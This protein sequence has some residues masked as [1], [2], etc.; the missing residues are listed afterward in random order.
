ME[1]TI[2]GQKVPSPVTEQTI[3]QAL[4]A[5]GPQQR[6][7]V[8]CQ[9][10]GQMVM[11]Q[12]RRDKGFRLVWQDEQADFHFAI[13]KRLDEETVL[14][15]MALFALGEVGWETAVTWQSAEDRYRLW[16]LPV[17]LLAFVIFAVPYAVIMAWNLRQNAPGTPTITEALLG[18]VAIGVIAGYIQYVDLFFRLVRPWLAV[19]LGAQL[20]VTVREDIRDWRWIGGSGPG[21]WDVSGGSFGHRAFLH[22]LD[23]FI[24]LVGTVGPVAVVSIGLFLLFD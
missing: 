4:Q 13:P 12:G 20:G 21:T 7:R 22:F 24:L 1:L 6:L 19:W 18:F 15:V 2:N 17:G 16:N 10:D 5:R 9:G 11:A 14:T 3:A 23:L 8:V